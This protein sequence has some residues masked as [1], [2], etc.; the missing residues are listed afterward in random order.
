MK[1]FL[2]RILSIAIVIPTGSTFSFPW[3][4][5]TLLTS[6]LH[7]KTKSKQG[8]KSVPAATNGFG[9]ATKSTIVSDTGAFP[10]LEPN[11]AATL[12]EFDGDNSKAKDLS[13]E[14][15][16]R[17]AEIYG[18][19]S[20][21]YLMEDAPEMSLNDFLT[22][23]TSPTKLK[24]STQSAPI[25]NFADLFTPDKG[26]SASIYLDHHESLPLSNLPP[27]DTFRVLHVDPLLLSIDNFFTSDECDDYIQK[28]TLSP[29]KPPLSPM[30]SRSRQSA[31]TPWLQLNERRRHGFITIKRCQNFWRKR[32]VLWD[33]MIFCDGK[34]HK[35]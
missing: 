7:A 34:S 26:E 28:S 27:F 21:N 18:F 25:T 31:K 22:S 3:T 33:W 5:G 8:T 13:A 35:R 11:V 2:C 19:R 9:G 15:Y 20:F 23:P 16:G 6:T 4:R 12:L 14:I 32:H 30:E 1:L 29:L 24:V 17:I 10:A